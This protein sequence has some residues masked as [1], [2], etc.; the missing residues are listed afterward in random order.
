MPSVHIREKTRCKIE[1][2]TVGSVKKID[3]N[4]SAADMMYLVI[5]TD[6][7]HI[8]RADYESLKKWLIHYSTWELKCF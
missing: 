1:R 6:F 7:K 3:E 2:A 8:C 5:E 4:V